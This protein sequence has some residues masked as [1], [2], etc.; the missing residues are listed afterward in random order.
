MRVGVVVSVVSV[1]SCAHLPA[2]PAAAK[3]CADRVPDVV[4]RRRARCMPTGSA[5]APCS[6]PNDARA[7]RSRAG[8]TRRR[9]RSRRS[10]CSS[11]ARTSSRSAARRRLAVLGGVLAVGGVEEV[12]V[13]ARRV[14]ARRASRPAR[15]RTRSRTPCR[16]CAE[17]WKNWLSSN[18]QASRGVGEERA[19][20]PW[21]T[22][23]GCPAARRRRTSWR[24][25]ARAS[26]MLPETS[27]A[28]ITAALVAGVARCTQL[29][30]AQVVVGE[31]RPGRPG[32]RGA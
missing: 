25:C 13:V 24:A 23:G 3:N 30:E 2:S 29:A 15:A 32:S 26:S 5:A 1:G 8:G 9:R 22:G 18:S 4:L 16:R 10:R 19:S 17:A 14:E 7:S 11:D 28:K 27:S 21:R 31:R 20:R 12:D 6:S